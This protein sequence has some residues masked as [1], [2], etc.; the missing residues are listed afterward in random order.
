MVVTNFF[1]FLTGSIIG[2]LFGFFYRNLWNTVFSDKHERQI[3]Y[4]EFLK[5]EVRYWG[6]SYQRIKKK[7]EAKTEHEKKIHSLPVNRQSSVAIEAS[8]WSDFMGETYGIKKVD[9]DYDK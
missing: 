6:E 1:I 2:L 5:L 4:I 7:C 8:L 9:V 3:K